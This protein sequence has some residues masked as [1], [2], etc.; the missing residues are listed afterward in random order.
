MI[1]TG[2]AVQTKW[3][4]TQ[5]VRRSLVQRPRELQRRAC[6][7]PC[8]AQVCMNMLR[9]GIIA[10]RVDV[11]QQLFPGVAAAALFIGTIAAA[12]GKLLVD[13]IDHLTGDLKGES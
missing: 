5:S 13:T 8:A 6:I 7:K 1:Q 9:A 3:R 10:Q 4:T 12:G 11:A 2:I